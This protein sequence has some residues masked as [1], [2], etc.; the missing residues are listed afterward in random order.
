MLGGFGLAVLQVE[1]AGQQVEY[2]GSRSHNCWN[3]LCLIPDAIAC[4]MG[5]RRCGVVVAVAIWAEQAT[6]VRRQGRVGKSNGRA[7]A[8]DSLWFP[9]FPEEG[10]G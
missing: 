7:V 8:V 6:V 1:A 9:L 3:E 2:M 10:F 4:S 5:G